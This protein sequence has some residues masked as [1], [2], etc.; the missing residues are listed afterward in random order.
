M[1][2]LKALGSL[3][4]VGCLLLFIVI[5]FSVVE[6]RYKCTGTTVSNGLFTPTTLY[7]KMGKYRWWVLWGEKSDGLLW[8]EVPN[9]TNEYYPR[10]DKTGDSFM[11][12]DLEKHYKGKFSTLSKNLSLEI[13]TGLF[14]GDCVEIK[15]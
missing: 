7:M 11:V 13:P 14:V 3:F 8:I 6:T 10:I 9:I 15:N 4:L 2:I 5:N 12:F 1:K